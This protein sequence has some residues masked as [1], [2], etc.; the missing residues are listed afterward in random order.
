M[1]PDIYA[2]TEGEVEGVGSTRTSGIAD[3]AI[4]AWH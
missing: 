2:K 1:I 3:E 4:R